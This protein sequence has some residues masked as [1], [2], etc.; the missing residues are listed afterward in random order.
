[1]ICRRRRPRAR[2][3][4]RCSRSTRRSNGIV[5]SESFAYADSLSDLGM[6]EL[7][8]TPVAVNPDARLSQVAGQRGWRVERWKMA[9]GNWRL[10]MPDPA[11]AGVPGGSADASPPVRPVDSV[12]AIVRASGGR[13]RCRHQRA[14]DAAPGRRGRSRELPARDWVRVMPTLSGICG[15]DLAAIG[16]HASLYLDPLTSYPFV[17]GHE[18]VGTLEDGSRVVIEPALGC[19][20]RGI[21]PP[22]PRCAEGTAGTLLQRHRGPDRGR[23]AD[24]LLR[25]HGRGMGRGPGGASEPAARGA[26]DVCPTRPPCSSSRSLAACMRRSAEARRRTTSWWC[27]ARE[28]SGF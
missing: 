6:L 20:V 12:V 19:E 4:A 1:M 15:S 17:P 5:L 28:R 8:G 7:V 25:R 24:G 26:V 3:G 11:L 21:E 18:V 14:L 2:R 10:P 22:C 16:G 13:P 23:A 27:R 9:P